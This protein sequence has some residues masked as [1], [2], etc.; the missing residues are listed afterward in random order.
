MVGFRSKPASPSESTSRC[1]VLDCLQKNG[2]STAKK[3]RQHWRC[4]L[5]VSGHITPCACEQV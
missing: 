4:I 5:A 2:M 3:Q 1:L